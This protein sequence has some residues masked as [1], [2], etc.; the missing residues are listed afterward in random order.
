MLVLSMANHKILVILAL[1]SQESCDTVASQTSFLFSARVIH[2]KFVGSLRKNAAA[3]RRGGRG[4]HMAYH[5]SN[6]SVISTSSPSRW[7]SGQW[8]TPGAADAVCGGAGLA[9]A[10]AQHQ[11][12]QYDKKGSELFHAGT[13]CLSDIS[14]L[15]RAAAVLTTKKAPCRAR[16]AAAYKTGLRGRRPLRTFH[17]KAAKRKT[18][19]AK[20]VLFSGGGWWIRTTEGVASRF[21]VCPLWPL[22]KSPIYN[23]EL[24]LV[25]GF[26]PPTC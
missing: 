9:A 8:R 21:T 23:M 22:G 25:D 3:H 6:G 5:A 18:A 20:Q 7:V 12:C 2:K 24:E 14:P 1:T 13:S 10:G 17:A 19:L 26:E 4:H 15:Y 11:Q 16:N